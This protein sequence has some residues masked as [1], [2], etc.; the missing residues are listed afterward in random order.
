M[1][2]TVAPLRVVLASR[3]D[4]LTPYLAA[5]LER[6]VRVVATINPDLSR[7]QWL[8]IAAITFRPTRTAWSERF[9]K[10]AL[11]RRMRSAN[12][13]RQLSRISEISYDVVLQIHCLFDAP[14]ERTVLYVDCT[15][16][17]AAEQWAPWNPLSGDALE[18]WY[19]SERAEYRRAAHIFAF[20]KETAR[21]LVQHY[22]VP[23]AKV[24]T[25]NMGANHYELPD[26]SA[27]P[28]A[29][30]P[31][32]LFIGNDFVR[33][34]GPELLTAFARVR[35]VVPDARLV[36]VGTRPDVAP[37]DGVTVLGRIR[38]RAVI[39]DL[40]ARAA[41]FV[42]PSHFDPLPLVLLEAMAYG[43]PTV[44]TPSC[45]IPEVLL[46]GVTGFSVPIGDA[47]ALAARLTELLLDPERAREMGRAGRA[48]VE[49]H[50]GWDTIIE[51]MMPALEGLAR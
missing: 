38:D 50:F 37:Q 9:F 6:Q 32:L 20:S 25:T 51:R 46:D 8:L 17:Q 11:G 40:Y 30:E 42:V 7:L 39:D 36:L 41:V 47:G 21:S 14:S 19:E 44:S 5:A 26:L 18:R 13:R 34:G 24:T 27:A 45:G 43:L 2:N 4:A 33:K 3:G 48:R 10:S 16:R 23:A 31:L 1:Q 29:K 35:A 28:V 22:G 49:A 15:H 12:A